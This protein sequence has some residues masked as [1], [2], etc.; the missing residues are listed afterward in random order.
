MTHLNRIQTELNKAGALLSAAEE[1]IGKGRIVSI[2][3]LADITADICLLIKK[4]GYSHC[5]SY[6]PLLSKLTE[7]M[8]R[9]S[10]LIENRIN[11]TNDES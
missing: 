8:D 11:D 4:E 1:L 9:L 7:Q 10:A 2:A 3:S 5:L 6:K